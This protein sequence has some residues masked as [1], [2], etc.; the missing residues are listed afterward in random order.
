MKMRRFLQSLI[1][2]RVV[3]LASAVSLAAAGDAPLIDA[4][5][6]RNLDAVRA[7]LEQRADVNAVQGDGATALHWASHLDDLTAADLLIRG[8]ANVN[9]ANDTG[10]TPLYLACTNRNGRM[11]ARLVTAGA[12]PN[13]VLLSGETVLMECARTGDW[14]P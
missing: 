11:V 12:N 6:N 10:V 14:T 3:L 13:A 2:P 9:A 7:L 5:K 8:G 4:I 1:G